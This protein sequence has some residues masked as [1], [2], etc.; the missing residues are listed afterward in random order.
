MRARPKQKK[1]NPRKVPSLQ[2]L[3]VRLAYWRSQIGVR[4]SAVKN[5]RAIEREI[6]SRN[7]AE[8]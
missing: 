8:E 7:A 5:V 1:P 2:E 4:K 3:R 6:E